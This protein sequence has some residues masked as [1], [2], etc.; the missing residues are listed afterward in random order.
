MPPKPQKYT[1]K[2]ILRRFIL[3][4]KI[5]KSKGKS[6]KQT[7]STK[8]SI[9]RRQTSIYTSQLP[10]TRSS[11]QK[12][13]SRRRFDTPKTA[14]ILITT[15]GNLDLTD[16]DPIR[17]HELDIKVHKLNATTPGV[18]NWVSDDD[19][20]DMGTIINNFIKENRTM[21]PSRL[22]HELQKLLPTLDTVY[23]ENTQVDNGKIKES[24]YF[25]I[26]DNDPDLINYVK[27]KSLGYQINQWKKGDL[28]LNKYYTSFINEEYD[29][30]ANPYNNTVIMLGT[31]GLIALDTMKKSRPLLR[32][33]KNLDKKA[34]KKRFF[35][36]DIL[37][38][39][40]KTYT[41]AVIVDLSCSTGFGQTAAR[42]L[43]R[44]KDE[45]NYGGSIV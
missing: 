14:I 4:S 42:H 9:S 37:E 18:C 10:L 34:N 41:D 43:R 2:N 26:G 1:K 11:R 3:K 12:E 39:L 30:I 8:Q 7:P 22:L 45:F 28:Y 36:K 27:N 16:P 15:H 29:T 21:T 24:D 35:L 38:E 32:K 33:D 20:V 5:L 17:P 31:D 40:D 6:K 19:L 25:E 23:Q 44:E 13:I